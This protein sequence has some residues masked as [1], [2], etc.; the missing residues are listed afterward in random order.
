MLEIYHSDFYE[1]GHNIGLWLSIADNNGDYC[2]VR[3]TTVGPKY[4][5]ITHT[6][7]GVTVWNRENNRLTRIY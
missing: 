6:D 4:S 2:R 7:G 5:R 3:I 1:T